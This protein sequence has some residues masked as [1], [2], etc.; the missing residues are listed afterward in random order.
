MKTKNV[1]SVLFI[2]LLFIADQVAKELI[3]FYILPGSSIPIIGKFIYLTPVKNEGLVMG[4]F[5]D[6]FDF[7]IFLTIFLTMVFIFF[8]LLK[9][10]KRASF[11]ITFIIA[12]TAGNLW[13][14]VFRGGVIDFVDVK[15]WPIFNLADIFI[16]TGTVLLCLSL[17]LPRKKCTE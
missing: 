11:G 8:W 7:P 4:F 17:I 13:D 5:P 15:F 16:V 3:T 6:S 9:F 2:L 14:R 1:I 10:R 12:G